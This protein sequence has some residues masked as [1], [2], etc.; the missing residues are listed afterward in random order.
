VNF[1]V[2][3][4]TGP[5]FVT[6][7]TRMKAGTAQKLVLNM[8]STSVMIRLGRVKGNKMIDMQLTNHKLVDRGT[9]MLMKALD[10]AEDAA[11]ELLLENGSVRKGIEAYQAKKA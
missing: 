7:S 4:V 6:G 2:E 3:V 8:L 9:K 5:E 10:I 1:P 11:R